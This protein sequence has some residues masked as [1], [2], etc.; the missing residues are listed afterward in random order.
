V[1]C[2]CGRKSKDP[3]THHAF[4]RGSIC[5]AQLRARAISARLIL[6]LTG[7]VAGAKQAG[8]PE[9]PRW[10]H[11]VD[12]PSFLLLA[13]NH[14]WRGGDNFKTRCATPQPRRSKIP[15][16]GP[17]IILRRYVANDTWPAF[18]AIHTVILAE[19]GTEVA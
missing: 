6:G 12:A 17:W 19:A 3:R 8:N 5:E 1:R 4:E 11:A 7:F 18:T 13:A 15:W 16:A 9:H 10:S 2:C 14:V